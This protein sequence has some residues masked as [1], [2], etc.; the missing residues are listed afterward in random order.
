MG[1]RLQAINLMQPIDIAH[2]AGAVPREPDGKAAGRAQIVSDPA[3]NRA[4]Q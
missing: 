3:F 1:P 4:F 2:C